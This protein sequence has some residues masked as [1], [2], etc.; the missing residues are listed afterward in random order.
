MMIKSD[1][2]DV[3]YHAWGCDLSALL[4][5][6]EA[7]AEDEDAVRELCRVRFSVARRYGLTVYWSGPDNIGHA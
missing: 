4:D 5:A 3:D 1:K 6:I 2:D 7:T